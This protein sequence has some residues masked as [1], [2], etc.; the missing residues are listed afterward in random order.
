MSSIDEL[1][2]IIDDALRNDVVITTQ[3]TA[4]AE[5]Y[6][7]TLSDRSAPV[8]YRC[9]FVISRFELVQ[10]RD[11]HY[12]IYLHFRRAYRQLLDARKHR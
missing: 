9:Q 4:D 6:L 7:W 11:P 2:N 3:Y 8:E 12:V 1:Q 5:G 10:V